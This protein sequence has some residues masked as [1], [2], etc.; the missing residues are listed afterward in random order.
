MT[1]GISDLPGWGYNS[2]EAVKHRQRLDELLDAV[3]ATQEKFRGPRYWELP[4]GKDEP[5]VATMLYLGESTT[6]FRCLMC[7][8]N[9]FV[10]ISDGRYRCNGCQSTYEG[11]VDDR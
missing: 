1:Y 10:K 7:K 9:V 2:R 6:A 8:A 3:R 5:G 4:V 11:M